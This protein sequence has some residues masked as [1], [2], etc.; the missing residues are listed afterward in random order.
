MGK[1]NVWTTLDDAEYQQLLYLQDKYNQVSYSNVS[2]SVILRK[3]LKE[4]Y[5][6]E[7]RALEEVK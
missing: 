7:T 1:H 3:A 5:L 6:M 2:F 4:L